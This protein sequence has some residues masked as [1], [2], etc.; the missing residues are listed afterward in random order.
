MEQAETTFLTSGSLKPTLDEKQ[1]MWKKMGVAAASTLLVVLFSVISMGMEDQDVAWSKYL[2]HFFLYAGVAVI[3]WLIGLMYYFKL[4]KETPSEAVRSFSDLIYHL[5]VLVV[6]SILFIS[7]FS[8]SDNQFRS[9]VGPGGWSRFGISIIEVFPGV[10]FPLGVAMYAF[11]GAF[12]YNTA[13]F[14]RRIIDDDF[15]P[16]VVVLGTLRVTLALFASIL[17]YFA[18]FPDV[19]QSAAGD[20]ARYLIVASFLAGLYPSRSL[21]MVIHWGAGRLSQL[22]PRTGK[23]TYT[24]LTI[25]QGITL[26]IEERLNEEGIDS[27]QAI[28]TCDLTLL[29]TKRRFPYPWKTLEDW[30]DQAK[31]A[32][33]FT[34][35]AEF[36][37]IQGLG[38][39]TYSALLKYQ[40]KAKEDPAMLETLNTEPIPK[41]RFRHFV[42]HGIFPA[43]TAD[44]RPK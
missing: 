23:Y 26:D 28:A 37:A 27:I 17:I 7:F 35:E 41:E 2:Y 21:K 15:I 9:L 30:I 19:T 1:A 18:F 3:Y 6:L 31:L 14:I 36:T 22:F 11:W 8:Y 33:Y 5:T 16:R 44:R 42:L 40:A 43:E 39:R 20:P 25:I 4:E 29:K 13:H 12:I 24:P 38:I 10:R 34:D 32:V